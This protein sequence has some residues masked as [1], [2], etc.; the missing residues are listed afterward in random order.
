MQQSMFLCVWPPSVGLPP[1]SHT[2]TCSSQT[3]DT[4]LC[5]Y[6]KMIEG[7]TQLVS[8]W[9]CWSVWALMAVRVCVKVTCHLGADLH[10]LQQYCQRFQI[11]CCPA[12]LYLRKL[13]VHLTE[14]FTIQ[15]THKHRCIYGQ[16]Q[17]IWTTFLIIMMIINFFK[18]FLIFN[19][20]NK[21]DKNACVSSLVFEI[22]EL[23]LQIA[24]FIQTLNPPPLTVLLIHFLK[25]KKTKK[26]T[27]THTLL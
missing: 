14:T 22:C 5:R 6:L 2:R 16:C 15:P 9:E 11:L 21:L 19:G 3:P 12:G 24:H 18:M 26:H 25:I 7:K 17:F 10:V 20:K 1:G 23:F 13:A 8:D 4:T 27:H